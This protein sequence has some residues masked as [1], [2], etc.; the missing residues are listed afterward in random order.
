MA[1]SG[2]GGLRVLALESRRAKEIATL[3]RICGG[4]PTVVPVMRE[5]PL[6]SNEDAFVF[7]Q[8]LIAGEFDLVLFLTGAG[9]KMLFHAVQTRYPPEAFFP[10]LKRTRIAVRGP[11]PAAVLRE[12]GLAAGIVSQEPSTWR[13][14]LAALDAA[15]PEGICGLRIGVQEYGASNLP[16]LDGLHQREALV[17]PVPVYQW[18]LPL[19]LQEMREMIRTTQRGEFDVLLFLTGI[20]ALHLCRVASEMGEREG[21]LQSLKRM[22]IVSVGPSTTEELLRQGISP[23]FQPSHP[24]MGILVAE[25]ARVVP[26]MIEGK[27]VG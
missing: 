24:K 14:V 15:Y 6:E 11:K 22:V 7:A 8:S 2:F 13:E 23:D 4:V 5:I 9:A 17:T 21:L 27:R 12:F 16:L 3:I 10:A 20:Q 18:A 26:G 1:V 25:A 19:D